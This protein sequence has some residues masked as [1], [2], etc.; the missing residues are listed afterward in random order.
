MTSGNNTVS[1]YSG[2][3]LVTVK[4]FTS[5]AGYNLAT[6][7]GTIDAAVFVPALVKEWRALHP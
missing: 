1:F 5:H 6:G 2:G 7:L 4:G 3:K